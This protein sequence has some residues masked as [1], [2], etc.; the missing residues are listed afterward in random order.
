M[1]NSYRNTCQITAMGTEPH[2]HSIVGSTEQ[3]IIKINTVANNI[4]YHICICTWNR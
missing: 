1:S 2:P 3:F 4:K